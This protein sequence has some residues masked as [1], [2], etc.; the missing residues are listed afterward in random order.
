MCYHIPELSLSL[1]SQAAH[2]GSQQ[3]LHDS[4]GIM[5][6][7]VEKPHCNTSAMNI[8]SSTALSEPQRSRTHSCHVL[9]QH[10]VHHF[11]VCLHGRAWHVYTLQHAAI[12]SLVVVTHS[13]RITRN[14][15]LLTVAHA[16]NSGVLPSLSD[17]LRSAPCANN[18]S[19]V[20][21][22]AAK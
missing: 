16:M 9:D 3:L 17:L 19:T 7:N 2:T 20:L 11:D 13:V 18:T 12:D 22:F 14:A 5:Y 1:R 4:V 21:L 10:V 15:V 8:S 6:S